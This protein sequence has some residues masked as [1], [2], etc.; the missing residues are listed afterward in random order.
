[1]AGTLLLI[2]TKRGLFLAR[3]DGARAH[4]TL[5]E[6]QLAGREV[7]YTTRDP[8]DGALWAAT[9]HVVWGAHLHRSDDGGRTWHVLE[10]A[11]HHGDGRVDAIWC[12]TP[13]PAESPGRLYAGIE[14]AGLFVSGDCGASWRPV[15]PLNR[16]PT[17]DAWQPAGGSL[18]LHSVLVDP[19]TPGRL[20]CAVSAG[21]VYRS[22]DDGATWHPKNLGV[23]ADFLPRRTPPAGQC[24]HKLILHPTRPGR[25]YMQNHCGTWRSD[26]AGDTWREI[27]DGLPSDYGYA[28]AADPR[29]PETVFVVPEESSHMRTTVDGRLRVYRSTDAG[30]SWHPLTRGLPQDHAY[31]SVLREGL[32]TDSAD[33]AGVYLGTSGGHVFASADAGESWRLIAG[34]LPRV[35]S[36]TAVAD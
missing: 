24:V 17:T 7:Y 10:T 9:R 25:L 13:G 34:F 27:T 19:H 5:S 23:R 6:P 1:M 32:C 28:L 33:P 16:H 30:A 18:A 29:D 8:R 26:D 2:G 22:D 36:L 14:P 12:I 31:L 35:L 21:G 3:S 11:P 4:W 20:F 15:A